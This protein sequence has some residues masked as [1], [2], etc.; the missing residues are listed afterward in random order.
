[1]LLIM[2]YFPVCGA[3]SHFLLMVGGSVRLSYVATLTGDR[4]PIQLDLQHR[5]LAE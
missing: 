1:M 5:N 3:G 2:L 4:M